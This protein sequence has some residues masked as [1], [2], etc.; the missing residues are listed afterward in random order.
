MSAVINSYATL[1]IFLFF[2]YTRFYWWERLNIN[3][4]E[5]ATEIITNRLE[6]F[7]FKIRT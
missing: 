6:D 1:N 3:K 7:E 2:Y 5:G 4:G